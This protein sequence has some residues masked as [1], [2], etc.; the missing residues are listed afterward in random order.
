V[1]LA[2]R[3]R[4][5]DVDDWNKLE[6]L[7]KYINGTPQLGIILRAS[8]TNTVTA[9]I[10]ASYGVHADAKSQTGVSISLGEGPFF[11]KCSKQ[12]VV[13]KSST[14]AEL[15]GLSDSMSQVIWSRDFLSSQGYEVPPAT[16]YQD[17]K[18]TIVMANKGRSTS[19]RTRHI[20]IRYFWVK[21]RIDAGEARLE[22]LPT[23]EMVSDILTKPLQGAKFLQ[24]RALLLNWHM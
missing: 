19:D 22:Y 2:T 16:V 17:N 13:S 8:P 23:D 5:P 20:N 21:D 6:R 10:D 14:E 3:V 4:D 15:I 12:K 7:L 1:F 9:F 18:S 24:L 11:A